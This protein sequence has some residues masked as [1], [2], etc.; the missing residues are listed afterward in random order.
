MNYDHYLRSLELAEMQFKLAIHAC[1]AAHG[2]NMPQNCIGFIW[3]ELSVSGDYL[4]LDGDELATAGSV[5]QH[6]AT[7]LL[8]VSIDT[9]LEKAF[10]DRLD[11]HTPDVAIAARIARRYASLLRAEE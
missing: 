5:L 10:P 1:S 3:G 2:G 4:K 9:A 7:Y 11:H 6:S 8:A